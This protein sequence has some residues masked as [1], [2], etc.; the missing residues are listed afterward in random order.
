MLLDFIQYKYYVFIENT[1]TGETYDMSKKFE[2]AVWTTHRHASQPGTFEITLKEGVHPTDTVIHEGSFITFGVNGQNY[3]YGRVQE[4]E[5]I[6]DGETGYSWRLKAY[7]S[8]ILLAD[9]ENAKREHGMTASDFFQHLMDKYAFKGLQGVILESSSIPLERE[10]FMGE[11]IFNMLDESL[12]M[13]HKQTADEHFMIRENLGVLEF[14][15][16]RALHTDYVVGDESFTN[17]YAYTANINTDTFNVIK[18]VRMNDS[19]GYID[20]WVVKDGATTDRWGWK[21]FHVDVKDAITDEE[22]D[23][24]ISL[25]LEA[26][27]RPVRN[28]RVTAVGIADPTMQAGAGLQLRINRKEIDHILFADS[29]THI[30][31]ATEHLMDIQLAIVV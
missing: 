19:T 22:I 13:T 27:N 30:W 3:F 29:V 5:L 11:S 25:V 20:T 7:N 23:T 15:E 21:Q 24:F 26:K 28:A 31:S 4:V 1:T 8:L 12:L 17:S 14:R 9:I 2:N 6:N 16:M 18:A 10:Y